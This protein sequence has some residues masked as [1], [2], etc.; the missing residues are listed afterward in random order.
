MENSLVLTPGDHTSGARGRRVTESIPQCLTVKFSGLVN[1]LPGREYALPG[2]HVR[3]ICPLRQV[4][5][6]SSAA[7]YPL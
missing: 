2:F 1:P 6:R 3:K 4:T 5:A 7:Y